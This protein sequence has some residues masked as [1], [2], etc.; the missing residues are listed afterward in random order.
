MISILLA[1]FFTISLIIVVHELGHYLAAR[2]VGIHVHRFSLGMGPI[3]L[4]W[5]AF[6]TEWALSLLPFGGYVK[7]AGMEAA[8]MEGDE[9]VPEEAIPPGALFRNKGLPARF[10]A[11]IAG[12]LANLI[13]AVVLSIG[14]LWHS[15]EPIYPGTWLDSPPAESAA[16]LAGAERGDRVLSLNGRAVSNW[17]DLDGELRVA[18]GASHSL[19]V[20]R[21]GQPVSLTLKW[22]LDADGA[23]ELGMRPLLDNRVGKVLRDGPAAKLGLERGDRILS[24]GDEKIDFYDDIARLVNASPDEPLT[25]IWERGDER[26]EGEVTPESADV[27]DSA[28]GDKLKTV[29]RIFF[30]PFI[31]QRPISFGEAVV[32]GTGQVVFTAKLTIGWLFKM[33]TFQGDRESVGGPILIFKTAGE[34]MRWGFSRLLIFI[35]FFSTQLCLLNLL[36]IPVLDGGHI[37]FLTLEALHLPVGENARMRL[38]VAGMVFL[39]GLMALVVL[40]D[41]GQ[42]LF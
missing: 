14:L 29:G 28:N 22:E 17:N 26:F 18:A 33:V 36:P 15:G 1:G 10:F 30:E 8:P 39:L 41:I 23:R 37:V 19:L 9:V 42:V 35:A 24:V 5:H 38:T 20:E 3:L 21:G 32:G 13:L 16:A 12:P 27:P 34:M 25:V 40:K 6:D 7:M 11:I 4:R 2:A 31:E